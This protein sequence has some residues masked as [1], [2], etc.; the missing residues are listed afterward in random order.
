MIKTYEELATA[1]A[2]KYGICEYKV[3]GNTMVYY[4]SYPLE[5]T[6]YKAT[7][8][9]DITHEFREA[10]RRYYKPLKRIGGMQVNYMV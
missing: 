4:T 3:K 1:Y 9:L 2:E 5:R 6:T 10:M 7:V 8:N